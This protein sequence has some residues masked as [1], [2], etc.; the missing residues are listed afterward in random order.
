MYRDSRLLSEDEELKLF[1]E[2]KAG[3]LQA[4]NRLVESKTR[5]VIFIVSKCKSDIHM[6]DSIQEGLLGVIRAL[7]KWD[8]SLGASLATYTYSWICHY[9]YRSRLRIDN[10]VRRHPCESLSDSCVEDYY[11]DSDV[12]MDG[13]GTPREVGARSRAFAQ[14][15]HTTMANTIVDERMS[16]EDAVSIKL[17]VEYIATMCPLDKRELVI[18]HDRILSDNPEVLGS[19]GERW[20]VSR[21][22]V[23]QIELRMLRRMRKHLGIKEETPDAS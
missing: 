2:Y 10:T 4:F 22:R 6:Q 3:S 8:P 21:E 14:K 12:R 17:D 23:R 9:A 1:H 15:V 13:Y 11:I 7:Q 18:M 5:M 19:L 20:G 16:I